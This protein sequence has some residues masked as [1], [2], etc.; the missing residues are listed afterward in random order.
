ML[1]WLWMHQAQSC[2]EL[3]KASLACSTKYGPSAS[4]MCRDQFTAYKD[5]MRVH[6][7]PH[8]HHG[9]GVRCPTGECVSCHSFSNMCKLT[10]QTEAKGQQQRA[11]F[12]GFFSSKFN[13]VKAAL[14]MGDTD[15]DTQADGPSPPSKEPS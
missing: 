11:Q 3:S 2:R 12:Y 15:S 13:S 6:V 8:V 5:C 7:R 4:T 1:V 9:V 14:G 10:L